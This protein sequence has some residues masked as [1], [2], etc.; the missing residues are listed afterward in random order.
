MSK[1]FEAGVWGVLMLVA[2]AGVAE[3]ATCTSIANGNWNSNGTWSC[4]KTPG[5]GDTVIITSPYTVN[6]NGNNRSASALTINAGGT[7]IDDGQDLTVS[8]N[9]VVNGTYDGS[10]SNGSLIMSGTG[11]TLSGTG[12]FIDIKRVEINGSVTIPAGSNLTFTQDS[13]IRV[14]G[15]LNL[16][17]TISG[18]GQTAGNRIL[19]V[20]NSPATLNIG[21][22]GVIDAPNSVGEIRTGGVATNSGSVSL[23]ALTTAGTGTWTNSPGSSCSAPPVCVAPP[24][25]PT[26]TTNAATSLTDSGAT[27]NGTVRSNGAIT[28]V[29]FDYGL[30]TSYGSTATATASP[31]A[32]NAGNTA[33]SAAVTGLSCATTYH[34]RVKGVNSVGTTNGG[35][36]SFMTSACI[37]PTV[38]SIT[39]ASFDPTAANTAVVWTVTFNTSVTGV[40]VNDF[41]LAQ[42]GG[43]T[44]ASITSVAGSGTTYAVTANT[45]TGTAGS[46]GLNLVDNDSIS[47]GGF[48]LGGPGAANGNFTGQFYTLLA[49]GCTGAAD[50]LFCDDF[51]RANPG[52]VGNGWTVTPAN[53]NNCTGAAGNTGCAGVDTDIP[54]FNATTNR[55]NPTRA[56]FTRWNIVTV[57]SPTINLAGKTAAQLSFWMRRGSD[58]FSECPEAAGENYLVNY[59]AS[60]GT[61]KV[62]AQYPSAPSAALCGAGIVYTPT[63]ELP[64]DAFHANFAMQFYQP[65]GSGKTGAGG[66]PGVVG[67]DYWHMDNVIVRDKS[68]A[69]SYVGAFCDNFEAGLGRWSVSAEGMPVGGNIGDANVSTLNFLSA[70]Q[71]LSTRWGYVSA[72]T[73]KTDMTGVTGNITYW[74]KSGV[75]ANFDPDAG[76]D[77]VVEYLNSAGV[78]TNLATYLGSAAAGTVYNGTHAIPS[79]AKHSSFR[80]RFRQLAGSKYDMDYWHLDDVCVG[81]PIPTADL[82]LVKTGDTV[83]PGTNTTYTLRVTN[84]GPGT[85]SGSMQ[86]V[87]TLP[88][89][90]S[91]LAGSGT[92]WSCSA[93]GQTVTCDWTGTLANGL[94]APDLLLTASVGAG[95]TGSITNTASVT[96][97]VVDNVPGNNTSS[98]TSGNFVPAY[99]FTDKACAHGV[100]IGAGVNPCNLVNWSNQIAGTSKTGIFITSVDASGVPT[101][102]SAGSATTVGF[103]F[104]MTCHDPIANAGV[105][106]SFTAAS[107][108]TLPLCTGNGAEP[109]ATSDW[110]ATTNLSFPAGSPS[111]A[112][113]Y[114]FT[115]ADVGEVE[116]FARNA[117]ATAQKATSNKFVVKPAGFVLSAI[118]RSS[119][120][121]AN[122]AAASPAGAAFVRAGEDFS[123]TVTA[124]NS[125]GNVTP[126]F[127]KEKVPESVLLDPANVTAGMVTPPDVLGDF[128]SFNNG[129]STGTAFTWS[130]VGIIT[131][132]PMIKD[133]NYLGAG[134]VTGTASGNVGRFYPDHFD[135]EIDSVSGVPMTCPS[136]LSCS[137]VGIVYSGQPFGLTVTAM[138]VGGTATANYNTTTGFSN[139]TTLSALG[140]LGADTAPTGAGAM[141]VLSVN[142]FSAGVASTTVEKYTFTATD[143]VPTNIH[144][145]ADDGE[146]SSKRLTDPTA[147]SVEAGVTVVSGRIK[148][149]NAYGS[150]LLPLS[151]IAS[152]QYYTA[153][154]WVP[155]ITDS[156]TH[157]TLAATYTVGAGTTAV[158]LTPSIGD[159]SNG[160]LTIKL[161]KPSGGASGAVTIS[162]T[163][164]SYLPVTSGTATFGI[165]KGNNNFIYQREAY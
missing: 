75:T 68:T 151:L 99:V 140:V 38:V 101:R 139:A 103:Q 15:T 10:G 162:P 11:K 23:Q 164:P 32:A 66:A 4:N 65:S 130:E 153:N 138:N 54:P 118:K 47:S 28:T 9:V 161:G 109:S 133:G 39:R 97:T 34:F 149:A 71:S 3:A 61:W 78:W 127:G 12:T 51:E 145:R 81:D 44:G 144:I 79:D 83:V 98:Y 17:G 50:I 64:A 36:L 49:S 45:G 135:T 141:D 117:A 33:V 52:V 137:G 121:F 126:N 142:A 8:G 53:V 106:A 94:A 116:L 123:V 5:A 107:S 58:T 93:V 87:D 59:R 105:Q 113:S 25:A 57:Q 69:P 84:N 56:M 41:V 125:A 155:S 14:N 80:L 85:L 19:R 108:A 20:D 95:V 46:L 165:Y 154:G 132:T 2:T 6:L 43:V 152:A 82:S 63:I 90:L 37:A 129:V 72:S 62:L 110:S 143:T 89:G 76:E 74:L 158:T 128:A 13:E 73:F 42:S 27:L 40:D 26:V 102:L 31:L 91:F 136:G 29:T 92:N 115:Y 88:T 55:A 156:V 35:D 122:P 163:A 134:D 22:T 114:A 112:T 67:Y 21:A 30:N 7:L 48:V 111:V 100:A 77:L 146:V 24:T 70:T 150:N 104:G 16:N 159:L 120:N 131:L 18:A 160:L 148:V 124:L 157:L 147:T 1:R 86:I 96:G 60:D 119:D